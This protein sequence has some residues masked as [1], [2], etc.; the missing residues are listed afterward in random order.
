[1]T[2]NPR[3]VCR[4]PGCALR[5]NVVA[6]TLTECLSCG[7]ELKPEIDL[8]SLFGGDGNLGGLGDLFG[9]RRG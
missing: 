5:D 6:T 1:M 3:V 4:K 8:S 2:D 9:K 7:G